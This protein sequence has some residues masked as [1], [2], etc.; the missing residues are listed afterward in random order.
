MSFEIRE[1]G[2]LRGIYWIH[3][4]KKLAGRNFVFPV[5]AT[6]QLA[7][8]LWCVKERD[9]AIF[10]VLSRY[11]T[12]PQIAIYTASLPVQWW[13]AERYWYPC[14]IVWQFGK[15]FR[16]FAETGPTLSWPL[17]DWNSHLKVF[18]TARNS[19]F[20]K[21]MFSQACVKN[22][23]PRGVC[24]YIPT[25]LLAIAPPLGRHPLPPRQT[26][27]PPRQTPRTMGY[28]Q[29][30]GG[31]HPTGMHSCHSFNSQHIHVDVF[32]VGY[33]EI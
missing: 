26:H 17:L 3:C 32:L 23:V 33:F 8:M 14:G 9:V 10:S 12:L 15:R 7:G 16:H 30:A 18:V 19:S 4:R 31:T 24:V 25:F 11:N 6:A 28:G 27:P 2:D 5:F 13:I 21:E 29:Q 1:N 22:S 20:G